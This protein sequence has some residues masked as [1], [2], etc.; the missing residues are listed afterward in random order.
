MTG[1]LVV[2]GP[3]LMKEDTVYNISGKA[4]KTVK[5]KPSKQNLFRRPDRILRKTKI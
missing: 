4:S 1:V 2:P 5:T 3:R